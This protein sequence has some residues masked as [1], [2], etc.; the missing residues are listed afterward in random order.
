[1]F[2]TSLRQL[3]ESTTTKV[4]DEL[5]AKHP[6]RLEYYRTRGVVHCFRE[7]FSAATKDFTYALK[8][9]RAVRRAKMMHHASNTQS[10]CR[11]SKSKRRKDASGGKHGVNGQAPPNGTSAM[12]DLENEFDGSSMLHPSVLPAAPEPIEPQCLFLRGA[13][14]LQHAVH[15]IENAILA[16]EGVKKAPT[17]DGA[18]LRLC[19]IENGRYGGVEIGNPDGPLGSSSGPKAQ[20]YRAVLGEKGFRDHI[21]TLLRKS[22][23]DHEKFQAHFDSL[24]SPVTIPDGDI[25]FQADYAYTLADTRRNSPDIP[26]V[27]TTY[28]PLLVESMYSALICQLMLADFASLLPQFVRTAIVVD[29]LEGYPVFLPPRSMAQAEFMELLDR[30]AG[31]WRLG[32]R[33]HSLSAQ[34]GK[35]RLTLEGP[36]PVSSPS[37]SLSRSSSVATSLVDDRAGSSSSSSRKNSFAMGSSSSQTMDDQI[38]SQA[39]SKP[40][41]DLLEDASRC[42]S[43]LPSPTSTRFDAAHALDCARMLLAPVVKR[44]HEKVEKE[45]QDKLS[46]AKKKPTPIS[47]PLHGPRVEIVLAWLA[48]VH[49]P[50]LE[51]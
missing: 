37:V 10:E 35:S 40:L 16:L 8:E 36:P 13:A 5:I 33:P 12:D 2:L 3:A 23:R 51:E 27:F 48:A 47:I 30:L 43:P 18:E 24:E 14:Y 21:T 26:P 9:A 20:A 4:L 22:L 41:A 17:I 25:A 38:G 45:R 6:S 46:G 49:L 31:G 7:E 19:Y 44:R 11:P 32:T 42:T 34:R 1:M 28:H 15:L 50:E 29:G 39:T